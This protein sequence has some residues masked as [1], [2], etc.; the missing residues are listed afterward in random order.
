[1]LALSIHMCD[2]SIHMCDFDKTTRNWKPGGTYL[3]HWYN[4]EFKLE[5]ILIWIIIELDNGLLT[6]WLQAIIG[7]LGTNFSDISIRI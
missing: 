7:A 2:L 1:M 4:K 5:S 3:Y 6:V